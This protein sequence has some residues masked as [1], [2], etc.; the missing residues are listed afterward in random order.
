LINVDPEDVLEVASGE[1]EQPVQAL[2]PD[3]SDPSLADGVGTRRPDGGADH[4]HVFGRKHLIERTA[5]LAV[6][7]MDKKPERPY[8]FIE[9][10]A[11]VPRL[12]AETPIHH[13]P[14]LCPRSDDHGMP[15]VNRTTTNPGGAGWT[16]TSDQRIMK[17][18]CQAANSERPFVTLRSRIIHRCTTLL[19][20]RLRV[21]IASF[22]V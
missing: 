13:Q 4:P 2:L 18:L 22:F 12:L 1:D 17:L 11:E 9:V 7:V 10:E 15:N 20:L 6:A 21:R 16:R 14:I 8:S 19:R 5:E 3:G